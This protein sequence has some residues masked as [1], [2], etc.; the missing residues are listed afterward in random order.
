MAFFNGLCAVQGG[1]AIF[2]D[3]KSLKRSVEGL[4][5]YPVKG[6]SK[7]RD[8]RVGQGRQTLFDHDK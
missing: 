4:F 1:T 7:N 3:G 8:A 5:Q 6:I 2:D